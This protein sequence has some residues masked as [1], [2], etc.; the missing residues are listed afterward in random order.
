MMKRIS[1]LVL[2]L[3]GLT[4]LHRTVQLC[5]F[6]IRGWATEMVTHCPGKFH[7]QRSLAG[8]SPWGHKELDTTK[9]VSFFIQIICS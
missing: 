6:S 9:P 5:F 3:E 2:V 4:G 7:G 1:F 8:Y